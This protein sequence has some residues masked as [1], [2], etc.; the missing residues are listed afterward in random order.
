[1]FL[2]H[3]PWKHQKTFVLLL[4]SQTVI[5]WFLLL[6]LSMLFHSRKEVIWSLSIFSLSV[7]I[8]PWNFSNI[9]TKADLLSAWKALPLKL[10]TRALDLPKFYLDQHA[11]R[12]NRL[13]KLLKNIWQHLGSWKK[14]GW[15]LL[16]KLFPKLLQ[17]TRK[18]LKWSPF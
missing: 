12:L 7:K 3:A 5:C 18:R 16:E 8:F 2:F 11:Q 15:V 1:M 10:R 14:P 17:V 13:C 4:C 9:F 6:T